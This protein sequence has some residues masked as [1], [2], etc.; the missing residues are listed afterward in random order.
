MAFLPPISRIVRLI[1]ICP[2]CGFAAS[3]WMRSPTSFDP[4][5]ATK[6]VP[7]CATSALPTLLPLPATKFTT[8]SGIPHSSSVWKNWAATVR[9]SLL[10][11]STTVLPVTMAAMVMPAMIARG[12]FHGGMTA[13][14]PSGMYRNS[15]RSP[16]SW[17]EGR[18]SSNRSA[19]RA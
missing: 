10:G 11:L 13:P 4:V 19:S 14:T 1:Q 7:G 18:A 17:I 16:G 9:A 3:S 15:S 8:P 5:K 2:G 12:K 6:R